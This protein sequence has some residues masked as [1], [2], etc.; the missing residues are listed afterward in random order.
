[1]KKTKK[2]VAALC[3]V[4]MLASVLVAVPPVEQAYAD[5]RQEL[6]EQ[7]SAA[8]QKA[9]EYKEQI[10]A[11]QKDKEKALQTKML[12]DQRNAV[13]RDQISTVQKQISY[14]TDAIAHY[15]QQETEQYK[16]FCKQVR[17]EEERGSISYWSVIFKA[18]GFADLLSRID[19]INEVMDYNQRVI[20]DLKNLRAQLTRSR[21]ELEEQ[22]VTLDAKQEELEYELEEAQ[23][24][25][26]EYIATEKGLQDMHD[27][28]EAEADRITQELEKYYEQTG[29]AGGGVTDS[30][31]KGVLG[32]LIWPSN[33]RYIT[34][35][36]GNRNTG[37]AGASTD[38]KGVDIGAPYYSDI[39]AAQS[40]T[41]IQA[42]WNGGYGYC[43]TIAH[44]EGVATLYAHMY[45]Y[46]VSVGQ[47]VSRGQ[48]I[49]ECGSSGISS[50]PHIHYEVRV[51]GTQIDPLPYLPGYIAYDW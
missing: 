25:I 5:T 19:F 33:A 24:I 1:M 32:G 43:V 8:E 42:G 45:D 38:H 6:Q 10:E 26:N 14:T 21:T 15:E 39:F 20:E 36:F 35:P 4:A 2:V 29:G 49:G 23:R 7:L 50:G 28:E 3:A 30:D 11:L 27:A 17:Q 46:Y 37:I 47:T 34:S 9:K 44:D 12:L 48:V 18:T 40:G 31:T 13:L 16:I 41:V 22:K 51:N